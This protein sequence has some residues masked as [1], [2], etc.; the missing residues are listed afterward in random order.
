M[1][2]VLLFIVLIGSGNLLAQFSARFVVTSVATR[3]NEDIY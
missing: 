3:G 1:R 2:T